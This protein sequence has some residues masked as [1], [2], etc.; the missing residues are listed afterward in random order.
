MSIVVLDAKAEKVQWLTGPEP[1]A[2]V[3]QR[4]R[5]QGL[6]LGFS[7]TTNK[8]IYFY[9]GDTKVTPNPTGVFV[10]GDF[11][12]AVASAPLTAVPGNV[13]LEF[14]SIAYPQAP[15]GPPPWLKFLRLPK[16]HI[17]VQTWRKFLPLTVPGVS[18]GGGE[19][20]SGAVFVN[21][22]I[23]VFVCTA[24]V[25]KSEVAWSST[26]N[27]RFLD[28]HYEVSNLANGGKFIINAPVL[29]GAD[30]YLWGNAHPR[31]DSLY[32]ARVAVTSLNDP[33]RNAWRYYAGI[34]RHGAPTWSDRET[35]AIALFDE[36][37]VSE[38]SVAFDVNLSKWLV[39]YYCTNVGIQLR[40]AD[41]PWGPYQDPLL[42]WG[43]FDQYP[44]YP[45]AWGPYGP[46]VVSR[47]TTGASGHSTVYFTM[48][49]WN[50]YNVALMKAGLSLA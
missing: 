42:L 47:F 46:G 43:Q 27:P 35:D 39:F 50:P 4:Y 22:R 33:S 6:D 12:D 11:G 36:S 28:Q 14:E 17:P 7:V 24:G 40:A 18:L 32:L 44:D 1:S 37:C 25:Q 41:V 31:A 19:T 21:N 23:H 5:F 13:T 34:N 16:V 3:N 38:P 10:D 26:A 2:A 20:P 45:D 30:V 15:V 49:M 29:Q 8:R 9:F 48:S